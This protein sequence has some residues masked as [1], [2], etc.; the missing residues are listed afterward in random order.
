MK[1]HGENH[2]LYV[3]SDTLCFTALK[4]RNQVDPA[5][6]LL[7]PVLAWQACLKI[8]KNYLQKVLNRKKACLSLMRIL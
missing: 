3:L 7:A 1:N 4:Q 8:F 2:G 6:F 5:H